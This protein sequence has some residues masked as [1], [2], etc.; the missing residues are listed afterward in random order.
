MTAA[1][2]SIKLRQLWSKFSDNIYSE[3]FHPS[4]AEHQQPGVSVET[5]RQKLE[6]W[7]AGIPTAVAQSPTCGETLTVFASKNWFSLAYDYSILLL[8]RNYIIGCR[9]EETTN[10]DDAGTKDQVRQRAFEIC[11]DHARDIC[12]LY[13]HLYQ[14]E[15]SHVQFTWGSLHILFLGGLTY[16][17]CLWQSPCVRQRT[18]T[19]TVM[20]T[21]MACTTVLIIIADRWPQAASYRDIFESLSERTISMMLENANRPGEVYTGEAPM[22]PGHGPANASG[23][24]IHGANGPDQSNAGLDSSVPLQDWITGLDDFE[25]SGDS[26]WLAQELFQGMGDLA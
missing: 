26:Q 14:T 8:Y 2:H 16:L 19:T 1:L 22:G 3:Q 5:L 6:E 11:A 13:R 9:D 24:Q 10:Q 25:A 7:R 20:N 15:G 17:Y 4:R 23:P 18:P 12:L 21:C